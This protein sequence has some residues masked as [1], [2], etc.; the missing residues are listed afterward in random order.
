MYVSDIC[1]SPQRYCCMERK[2]RK[3]AKEEIVLVPNLT[4]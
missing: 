1:Q 4:I 2:K 3:S